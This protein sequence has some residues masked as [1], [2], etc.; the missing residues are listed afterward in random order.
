M[1]S[2]QINENEELAEL[3]KIRRAFHRNPE[4]GFAEF[5]TTA[6]IVE[7]LEPLGCQLLYGDRLRDSLLDTELLSKN[8]N[9]M[10]YTHEKEKCCTD[11]WIDKIQ[12]IT[13]L[14]AITKRQRSRTKVCF[15]I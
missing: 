8:Q 10:D 4:L 5:W 15:S 3:V 14:V 13:G 6:R 7:Y 11:D 2:Y 12:R 9:G 1:T